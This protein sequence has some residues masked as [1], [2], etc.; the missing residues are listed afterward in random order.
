MNGLSNCKNNPWQGEAKR[1]LT[2]CSAGL[3]RSPTAAVVLTEAFKYNCRAAGIV[4][5][6]ALIP[7]SETLVYWADEI[8]FMQDEHLWDF[9]FKFK[10]SGIANLVLEE[11]RY[12]VLNIPD[13]YT[14]MDEDL[15]EHILKRYD[16]KHVKK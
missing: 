16:P 9:Q 5:E 2:I 7:V 14:R 15:V 11:N 1:V 13:V 8:V 12:Q 10:E 4:D 6:Y 3:L